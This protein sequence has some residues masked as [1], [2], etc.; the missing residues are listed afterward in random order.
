MAGCSYHSNGTSTQVE[1]RLTKTAKKLSIGFRNNP[2]H[3]AVR[4]FM[5]ATTEIEG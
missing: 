2:L 5:R 3:E 4:R 1:T